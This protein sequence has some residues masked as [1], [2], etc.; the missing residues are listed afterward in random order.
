M[1]LRS[2]MMKRF[3]FGFQRR[4]WCPKWT[5]LSRSWRMVT[6]AMC[7]CFVL[8]SSTPAGTP[9]RCSGL[10]ARLAWR[11][12]SVVAG[13]RVSPALTPGASGLLPQGR[14]LRNVARG[15]PPPDIGDGPMRYRACEVQL[16]ARAATD[17]SRRGRRP[18]PNRR[19][20][21]E[22]VPRQGGHVLV[23]SPPSAARAALGPAPS[24]THAA[25]PPQRA[26]GRWRRGRR[27]PPDRGPPDLRDGRPC[28]LAG[29][30]HRTGA[31]PGSPRGVAAPAAAAGGERVRPAVDALGLRAPR[32]GPGREGGPTGAGRVGRP[33]HLRRPA[34]RP[35]RGGRRPRNHADDL[36]AGP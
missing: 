2:V 10:R 17:D 23:H 8:F 5:P 25:V 21:P 7:E 3:I 35:R 32:G 4:V 12:A 36:R 6:T 30:R 34:R 13:R 18:T 19:D 33:D 11:V 14:R 26:P 29:R 9:F 1:P 20:R 27:A 31:P 22:T 16:V 28:R 24:C 15:E